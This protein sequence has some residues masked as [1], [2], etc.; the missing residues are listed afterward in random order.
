[1]SDDNAYA[2]SIFRICKYRPD[3]PAQ[4]FDSLEAAREWILQFLRWHNHEHRHS[5]IRYV[6]PLQRHEG[7]DKALLEARERSM[8]RPRP[9]TRLDGVVV[10]PIG[11]QPAKY[12]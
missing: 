3:W 12:L 5:G 4:G 1:M 11:R 9:A 6:T 8:R 7:G 2:E 10:H